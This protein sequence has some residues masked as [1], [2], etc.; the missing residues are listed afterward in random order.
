MDTTIRPQPQMKLRRPGE[1]EPH[2]KTW[3]A[4]PHRQ[5]LYGPRLA[6]MQRAY[7]DVAK[8]I[9]QFEPV[10]MVAHPEHTKSARTLLGDGIEIVALPIDDCWIRDSGPTFLKRADGGLAGVSWRFNAWGRKHEPFDA[11]DALAGRVLAYEEAEMF[12][13]F[14]HCEGGSLACD[15]DG[16]L[17]VTETSLLH[18]NRNPG[19]SKAWVEQELLRMLDVEKVVWLPGDPLDLETDGHVDGMCCFVRPGVVMFEYNPDPADLHGRILADNLVALKSQTDARGR[20]FEVIPIPEA[21]DVEATS[22]VFARSYINFA[23]ANGGVVM[24]TF[25]RPSGEEAKAA[26]AKAF[27]DR[28]IVTVDVGAVVPAGGAIHCITQEQPL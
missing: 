20:S 5:D 19:L 2:A 10:S 28:R 25:G 23:L 12:R 8:A 16:T 22:E 14:L 13:S 11:D 27:P 26:V 18:P 3:M 1:F 6:D 17:I 15:G 4:W 9:A 7:A 21:Y 24:P